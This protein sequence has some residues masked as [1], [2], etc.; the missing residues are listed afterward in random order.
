MEFPSAGYGHNLSLT[1]SLSCQSRTTS[2]GQC[3]RRSSPFD[4][5]KEPPLDMESSFASSSGGSPAS[6]SLTPPP[7]AMPS[8]YVEDGATGS[9]MP[10]LYS[11][12]GLPK[13]SVTAGKQ[14]GYDYGSMHNPCLLPV[15]LTSA[16]PKTTDIYSTFSGPTCA[17][18]YVMP[19]STSSYGFLPSAAA[20]F[21]QPS[22]WMSSLNQP[23]AF[24]NATAEESQ[25]PHYTV[26]KLPGPMGD[27]R[28]QTLPSQ[29]RQQRPSPPR[30]TLSATAQ[31]KFD[32]ANEEAGKIMRSGIAVSRIAP[33]SFKCDDPNCPKAFKRLEHLKR[34][35]IT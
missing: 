30:K 4:D 35:V 20:S 33:G 34:H 2:F 18:P 8:Y 5:I 27:Y 32:A 12:S 13:L 9:T 22:P 15:D 19:S 7:P 24:Y 16:T 6:Y 25:Q 14:F 21:E 11:I 17:S 29:D 31:R 26:D 10:S 23:I 1:R 3:S 28:Q